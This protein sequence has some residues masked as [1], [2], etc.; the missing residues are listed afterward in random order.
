VT[1]SDIEII[2]F[3]FAVR[4]SAFSKRHSV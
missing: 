4:N 3:L 1:Q 2:L